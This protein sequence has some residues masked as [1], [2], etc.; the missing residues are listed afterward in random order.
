MV[1]NRMK[2]DEVKKELGRAKEFLVNSLP[3]ELREEF[4]EKSFIAGGAVYSLF[5]D[6]KPMDYDFFLTDMEIVKKVRE[7]FSKELDCN[8]DIGFILGKI[9]DNQI[10]I[11][12]NAI[13]VKDR[14]TTYQIITR[15]VGHPEQVVLEFDFLHNMFYYYQDEISTLS[16]WKY[17]DDNMLRFNTYRVRD[18]ANCLIR[19]NKFSKRGFD[20]E[21]SEIAKILLKLNEVGFSEADLEVLNKN[22]NPNFGS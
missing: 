9:E 14:T 15:W 10:V 3:E 8:E 5:N 21:N 17:L 16:K 18:V 1:S 7:H 20:I 11:T 19:V 12:K 4:E 6:Q 2:K 13:T 22:K